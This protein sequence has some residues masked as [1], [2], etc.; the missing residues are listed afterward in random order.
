M[1]NSE[2]KD[3]LSKLV[4]DFQFA[5]FNTKLRSKGQHLN[6]EKRSLI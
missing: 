6:V 3:K 4:L 2:V 1:K 5:N